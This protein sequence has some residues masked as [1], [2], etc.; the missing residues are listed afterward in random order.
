LESTALTPPKMRNGLWNRYRE[1]YSVA[2]G[3]I[4]F[5]KVVQYASAAVG[6]L[7][8]LLSTAAALSTESWAQFGI[9]VVVSVLIG[10]GGWISGI[11]IMAQGQ[12]IQAMVDT[13]IN[14]SPLLDNSS[15]AQFLGVGSDDPTAAVST[16]GR[17][18][19]VDTL[20]SAAEIKPS[21]SPITPNVRKPEL[22]WS[23][24]G[25]A[26]RTKP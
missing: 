10:G 15:K 20:A 12:L 23:V 11:V 22:G 26:P 6:V 9:G 17:N 3:I 13:S 2:T 5:G 21:A 18:V 4:S 16:V 19:P 14:T 8:L 25:P 7:I 1:A 24:S